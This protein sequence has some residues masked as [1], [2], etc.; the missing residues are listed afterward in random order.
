MVLKDIMAISGQ[1]GLFKFIAQGKNAIIVE[2]LETKKRSSAFSTAKVSSLEEISIFTEDEDMPLGK[3][4]DLIHEKE[5]GGPAIDYKSEPGRLK[6]WFEEIL[7]QYNREKVYVSDIKKVAHWYNILHNLNML[8]KE[9]PEESAE[10]E[11]SAEPD[12]HAEPGKSAKPISESGEKGASGTKETVRKRPSAKKETETGS[13]QV[14]E[15]KRKPAAG[16][17]SS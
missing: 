17:K 5:N 7:P 6:A 14:S 13:K 12:G 8:V 1:S 3:V 4:F 2:H 15:K 9:E 11:K 10:P 16:K